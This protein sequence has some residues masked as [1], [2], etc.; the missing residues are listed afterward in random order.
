MQKNQKTCSQGLQKTP[1]SMFE[2]P[3]NC[4]AK[5]WFLQYHPNENLVLRAPTV[6]NS[7]QKS[8]QKV[9]WKQAPTKTQN[10]TH[11]NSK[12]SQNGVPKSAKITQSLVLGPDVSFHGPLESP[13][14]DKLVPRVSKWRHQACQ[15]ICSGHP[16]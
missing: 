5:T 10:L 7:T 1:E 15:M 11:R 14:A 9:A 2:S 8:M 12:N 4:F 6:N 13:Q 16:K 3:K